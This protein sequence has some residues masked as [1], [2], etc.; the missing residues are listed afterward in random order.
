MRTIA[1]RGA[2]IL[3][4]LLSIALVSGISPA[5][6]SGR[7]GY[8]PTGIDISWPQCGRELNERPNFAVVG[9]TGGT[10]ASTNR[11][12]VEQLAWASAATAGGTSRQPRL[13][14]YVNT[15]NPG[16][17]LEQ[18]EVA[19]WPTSNVDARGA[20]SFAST[21]S[22]RRNP[23]GRCATSPHEY[24]SYSNDLP[25]SWQYG[26]NRAVEAVDQRFAPAARELGL[27]PDPADYTWWLDVETMNSWQRSGPD[28]R[29]RNTAAIEG[30]RQFLLA[31][32]ARV[33]LY[34][35]HLQWNRIVG[36]TLTNRTT[37]NSPAVGAYLIGADTWLAGASDA[38]DAERRCATAT[39]LSGGQVT[40]VQFISR[41]LDVNVSCTG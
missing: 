33:G 20:D 15:A 23:Y 10:A 35:T 22:A 3:F 9:V 8:A 19:S 14:L 12:L 2:F 41:N 11:C 28:A 37:R 6:A 29:A 30:M 36:S 31:E 27:S 5:E 7:N 1:R 26:W 16:E 32:G 18:Y 24:R 17:V 38:A 40:L 4:T 21:G 13:Q 34:S 25:C 39:G